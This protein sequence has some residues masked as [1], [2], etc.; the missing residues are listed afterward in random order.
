MTDYLVLLKPLLPYIPTTIVSIIAVGIF[1]FKVF[2]KE[3]ELISKM[4]GYSKSLTGLEQTIKELAKALK[5]ENKEIR[6]NISSLNEKYHNIEKKLYKEFVTK[7][8]IKD[9]REEVKRMRVETLSFLEFRF[10]KLEEKLERRG[11]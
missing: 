10:N 7:E 1:L 2:S 4:E 3:R 9:F 8:E 11:K 5:E 6:N